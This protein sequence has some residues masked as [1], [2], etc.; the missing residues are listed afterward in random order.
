MDIQIFLKEILITTTQLVSMGKAQLRLQTPSVL[1]KSLSWNVAELCNPQIP[2]KTNFEPSI[3][4]YWRKRFH[5]LLENNLVRYSKHRISQMTSHW[6]FMCLLTFSV[7]PTIHQRQ[8][9]FAVPRE[10]IELSEV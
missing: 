10:E 2:S 9:Y 8:A 6:E 7:K 5:F 4:H 1:K 3:I